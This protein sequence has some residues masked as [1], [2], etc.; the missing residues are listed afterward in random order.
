MC[1][2]LI[3]VLWKLMQENQQ[4]EANLSYTVRLCPNT[5]NLNLKNK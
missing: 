2:P 3:L 1:M 4:F 5:H